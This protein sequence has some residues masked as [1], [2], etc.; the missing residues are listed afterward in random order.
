MQATARKRMTQAHQLRRKYRG[1]TRQNNVENVNPTT[2]GRSSKV[3]I[4]T[5]SPIPIIMPHSAGLQLAALKPSSQRFTRRK[6]QYTL[7]SSVCTCFE[8]RIECRVHN[9]QS[10]AHATMHLRPTW[11]RI[12]TPYICSYANTHNPI[13]VIVLHRDHIIQNKAS[14]TGLMD[15]KCRAVEG[16]LAEAHFVIGMELE[17]KLRRH[18]CLSIAYTTQYQ[19]PLATDTC[20]CT[21]TT[22][23]TPIFWSSKNGLALL[24]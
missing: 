23:K 1:R 10:V 9:A 8:A 19:I 17:S 15:T 22:T 20:C 2:F 21:Y 24:N 12:A 14:I 13:T 3:P 6:P 5:L 18:S 7:R 11:F 16:T 4:S